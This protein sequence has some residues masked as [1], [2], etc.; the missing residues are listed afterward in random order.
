MPEQD[1]FFFVLVAGGSDVQGGK[2][3]IREKVIGFHDPRR[4]EVNLSVK[5]V[6][7]LFGNVDKKF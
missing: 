6:P 5:K 3:D 1:I 2:Y 7:L 4:F